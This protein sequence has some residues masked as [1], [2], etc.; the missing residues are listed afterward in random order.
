MNP[1]ASRYPFTILMEIKIMS[2]QYNLQTHT[3]RNNLRY[4]H[5]LNGEPG[6]PTLPSS[7]KGATLFPSSNKALPGKAS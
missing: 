5:R 1:Q 6:L 7:S 2:R 4:Q 3:Q